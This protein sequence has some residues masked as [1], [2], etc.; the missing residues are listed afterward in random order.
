M[1]QTL[2]DQDVTIETKPASDATEEK[3]TKKTKQEEYRE[4]LAARDKMLADRQGEREPIANDI[5]TNY[6]LT[7]PAAKQ[8]ADRLAQDNEGA[9]AKPF[10]VNS[11][12]TAPAGSLAA[13]P[14][15][16][17]ESEFKESGGVKT[18]ETVA[19]QPDTSP[20]VATDPATGRNITDENTDGKGNV[21]TD[22]KGNIKA[23]VKNESTASN[24]SFGDPGNKDAK[25]ADKDKKNK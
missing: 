25:A 20:E 21:I 4:N 10:P 19:P 1:K 9:F 22:E 15:P 8:Q 2:K 12:L 24:S 11:T 17:S 5:E 13:E 18:A 14:A 7:R 23:D 3:V 16:Q 6:P